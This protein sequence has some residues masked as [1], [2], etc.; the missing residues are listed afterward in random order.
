MK[1]VGVALSGSGFLFPAHVGALSAITESGYNITNVSGTS[2]GGL[3]AALYA[4]GM[5]TKTM[6]D[7]I[8]STDFSIFMKYRWWGWWNGLCDPTPLYQFMKTH[9]KGKKFKDTNIPLILMSCNVVNRA[10]FEFSTKMTPMTEIAIGARATS[11]IPFIYPTVNYEKDVLVDGGVVNNIPVD[12]LDKST[13][14]IG[15]DIVESQN[16]SKP[17]GVISMAQ[18]L[19]GIMLDSNE[20]ARKAWAIAT[21][22]DVI[23]VQVNGGFLDSTINQ[24][25]ILALYESGFNTTLKKLKS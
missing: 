5:D 21:D 6:K 12:K 11:S 20:N 23:S 19:V 9:T 14:R 3:V 17:T 22:S 15:V 8:V 4:S 10:S 25:Q 2:G 24:K 18:R 7:I 13:P 1:D 16:P